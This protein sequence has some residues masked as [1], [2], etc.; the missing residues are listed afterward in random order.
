[1]TKPTTMATTRTLESSLVKKR[2]FTYLTRKRPGSAITLYYLFIKKWC[3]EGRGTSQDTIPVCDSPI[4]R[5]G[6]LTLTI[7]KM[8]ED[9]DSAMTQL[10]G[11]LY[12]SGSG[13]NSGLA[14]GTRSI[15][16]PNAIRKQRMWTTKKIEVM[17]VSGTG[18][19]NTVSS[20]IGK[21][22]SDSGFTAESTDG[23]FAAKSAG[24]ASAYA[25]H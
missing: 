13:P 6:L 2:R 18:S 16:L 3:T 23:W 17:S 14:T 12:G 10:P 15:W 8:E 4:F 19:L 22:I 21:S 5:M 11:L 1:M 20:S 25:A 24:I 7:R 9:T